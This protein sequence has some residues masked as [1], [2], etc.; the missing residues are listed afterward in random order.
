MIVQKNVEV[1]G[2]KIPALG[3]LPHKIVSQE[4]KHLRF[5]EN[6][7]LFT[8]KSCKK[9]VIF[10]R[11]FKKIIGPK[12]IVVNSCNFKSKTC[13]FAEVNIL[14]QKCVTLS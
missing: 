4:V 2:H 6:T 14:Q 8:A 13:D 1:M 7:F 12:V 3:I 10:Q 11:Q 5:Y 9:F